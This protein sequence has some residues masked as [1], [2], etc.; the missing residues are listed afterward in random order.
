[1]TVGIFMLFVT[2]QIFRA[3]REE[4]KLTK[5]FPAYT[6]GDDQ[7]FTITPDAG[8]RIRRVVVDGDNKGAITSYTFKNVRANHT[9]NA[10]FR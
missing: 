6:R 3:R 5:T 8:H 10:Y 9:I 1:M 7:K 2:I 4:T